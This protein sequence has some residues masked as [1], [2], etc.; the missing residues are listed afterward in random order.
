MVSFS[1]LGLSIVLHPCVCWWTWSTGFTKG[2]QDMAMGIAGR[3][4]S[5]GKDGEGWKE[6]DVKGK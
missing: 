2:E 6:R 3:G 1:E 5:T 4:H